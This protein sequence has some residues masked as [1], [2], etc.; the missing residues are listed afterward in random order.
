MWTGRVVTGTDEP[1]AGTT[2]TDEKGNGLGGW[3]RTGCA[4]F[5]EDG[6]GAGCVVS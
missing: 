5:G 6:A 2:G 4:P 1:D 3:E